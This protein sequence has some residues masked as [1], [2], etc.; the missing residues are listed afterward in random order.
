MKLRAA[1][2]LRMDELGIEPDRTPA[3]TYK[4]KAEDW[5]GGDKILR[6][7]IKQTDE[8]I[9]AIAKV[10]AEVYANKNCDASTQ[11]VMSAFIVELYYR[12]ALKKRS[13]YQRKLC[14]YQKPSPDT[15]QID[16]QKLKQIPI[17][18]LFQQ[19]KPRKTSTRITCCCPFHQEKTPSFVIY[20]ERNSF[21]CYGACNAHGDSID[22]IKKL[23]NKTF[24]EAVTYLENFK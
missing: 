23:Y 22:F 4:F 6:R 11:A 21:H 16:I 3:P 17:Q 13:V 20:T 5:D 7:L 14:M 24:Q 12:P 2:S 10:L 15:K 8:E 19:V 9:K 18:D 1:V